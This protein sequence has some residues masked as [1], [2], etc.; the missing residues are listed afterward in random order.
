MQVD[1]TR[2]RCFVCHGE[3]AYVFCTKCDNTGAL[4]WVDGRAYPYTPEGEKRA[5]KDFRR[6]AQ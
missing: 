5:L 1:L 6:P 2:I 3:G 4:F